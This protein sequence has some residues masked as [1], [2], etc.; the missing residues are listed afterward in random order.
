MKSV[1]FIATVFLL[2]STAAAQANPA[3]AT[4]QSVKT[5]QN[6]DDLRV[7]IRFS[8]PVNFSIE[9]AENPDR[10]LLDVPDAVC[11]DKT[12]TV[13]VNSNGVRRVRTGQHSTS[14]LV[15][16]IVLDL[17]HPLQYAVSSDGNVVVLTVSPEKPIVGRSAPVAATSGNLVGIFHRRHD[18]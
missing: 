15:T 18:T 12:K 5:I 8:A 2:L 3:A 1:Q 13:A 11:T 14:P 6:G 10:I 17:E 16:R 9:T 7:E 4:V